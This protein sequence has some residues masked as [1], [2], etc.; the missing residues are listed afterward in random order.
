MKSGGFC[1][2]LSFRLSK[3][4]ACLH[5]LL[6]G[7]AFFC[8]CHANCSLDAMKMNITFSSLKDG[9]IDIYFIVLFGK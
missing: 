9:Y 6:L 4:L 3:V 8:S 2:L 5:S 1:Y 7:T